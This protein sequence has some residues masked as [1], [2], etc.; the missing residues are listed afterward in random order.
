MSVLTTTALDGW[1]NRATRHLSQDAA[2]QVRREIGEHYE[3]ARETA[4]LT[5]ATAEEA[6]R[7]AIAALGDAKVANCQY[8]QVMLT[9]AEARLLRE[10]NWEARAVCSRSW[11]R[12]LFFATAFTVFFG[13]GVSFL[14]GDAYMGWAM[15]AGGMCAGI[16]FAAPFLPIYTPS[17]ARVFRGVRWAS[18][19]GVLVLPFA[20]D[21]YRWSW[22]ILACAWPIL[23]T[24]WARISIRRKL[25]V[26]Q[27]PRHLYL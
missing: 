19:L 2:A 8:R 12:W 13:A 15:A 14:K 24:E 4:A 16:L 7:I 20:S 21:V 11:L 18:L 6:D 26:A 27:W 3:S 25:P 10:G 5:A 22:L 23:Q 1:L 9:S 17:R